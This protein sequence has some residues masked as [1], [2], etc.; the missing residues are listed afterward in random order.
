MSWRTDLTAARARL[1]ALEAAEMDL[2][3]GKRAAKIAAGG[4]Q[5]DFAQSKDPLA[6]LRR[7]IQETQIVIARLSGVRTGGVIIPV[8]GR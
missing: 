8:L 1:T 6:D 4:E 7:A 2:I 3:T 5:I